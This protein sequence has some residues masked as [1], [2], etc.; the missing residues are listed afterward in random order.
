[1]GTVKQQITN[2][3]ERVSASKVKKSDTIRITVNGRECTLKAE[4]KTFLWFKWTQITITI[5]TSLE[6][7]SCEVVKFSYNQGKDLDKKIKDVETK[8]EK[9]NEQKS[10]SEQKMSEF[11]DDDSDETPVTWA[12][13]YTYEGNLFDAKNSEQMQKMP[14]NP[15]YME[16]S[17]IAA[18]VASEPSHKTS[19]TETAAPATIPTAV[20]NYAKRIDEYSRQNITNHDEFC[21]FLREVN[22][23]VTQNDL[24]TEQIANLNENLNEKVQKLRENLIANKK[25][26]SNVP[27]QTKI[28]KWMQTISLIDDILL[29][30]NGKPQPAEVVSKTNPEVPAS[31]EVPKPAVTTEPQSVKTAAPATIPTAVATH[32][33]QIDEQIKKPIS[34][35]IVD[36]RLREINSL[37]NNIKNFA[38]QNDLTQ[39]EITE[40]KQKV[41]SLCNA[42]ILKAGSTF[43]SIARI[44]QA[45]EPEYVNIV[46]EAKSIKELLDAKAAI[47]H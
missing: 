34:F 14:P 30:L 35:S 13:D 6:G 15:N 24:T 8:C 31:S 1:M 27:G 19:V 28:A 21:E 29:W 11:V 38:Q 10:E 32:I 17:T 44:A 46:A 12:G 43:S 36:D 16:S 40:L 22:K 23:F 9:F 2:L 42:S 7:R 18:K 47:G 41:Q 4:A 45:G 39:E 33:K 25:N 20:A 5:D 3:H 37:L 26:Y